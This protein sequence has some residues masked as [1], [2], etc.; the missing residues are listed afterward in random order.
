M[1]MCYDVALF[2]LIANDSYSRD[3]CVSKAL[4]VLSTNNAPRE[5]EREREREVVNIIK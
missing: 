5:R 2:I 1:L 4:V 3:S